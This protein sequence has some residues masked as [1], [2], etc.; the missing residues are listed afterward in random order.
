MPQVKS[1]YGS[2]AFTKVDGA[3]HS[4]KVKVTEKVVVKR[5]VEDSDGLTVGCNKDP[6]QPQAS[7]GP[8]P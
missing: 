7:D 5:M 3:L 1:N 2:K 8:S 6:P 4:P